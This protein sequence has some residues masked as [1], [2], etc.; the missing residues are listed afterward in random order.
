MRSDIIV[1]I[2]GAATTIVAIIGGTSLYNRRLIKTSNTID[3]M[4][5]D[6]TNKV[7]DLYADKKKA[8]LESDEGLKHH[9]FQMVEGALEREDTATDEEMRQIVS[10]EL[11]ARFHACEN[12]LTD[13]AFAGEANEL[14]INSARYLID[15]A[16]RRFENW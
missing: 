12:E 9:W 13:I 3:K 11:Y 4:V 8:I 6:A 10:A 5:I 1:S 16:V 15:C 7:K 2:V 14:S